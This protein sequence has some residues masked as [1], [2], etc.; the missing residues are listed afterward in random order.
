MNS[1]V[2]FLN[3]TRYILQ[4]LRTNVQLGQN[5][6]GGGFNLTFNFL[7]DFRDYFS[8]ICD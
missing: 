3:K 7:L 8:L 6:A 5:R 2:S 4:T 1:D